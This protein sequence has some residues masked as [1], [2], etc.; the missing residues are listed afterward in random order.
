MD[1]FPFLT[2]YQVIIY[3]KKMVDAGNNMYLQPGG[4][5]AFF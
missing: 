3:V 5:E 4:E 1:E 2:L